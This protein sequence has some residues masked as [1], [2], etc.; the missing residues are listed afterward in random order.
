MNLLALSLPVFLF[1]SVGLHLVVRCFKRFKRVKII[2]LRMT[3]EQESEAFY[4]KALELVKEAG[5][6]SMARVDD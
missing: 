1:L 3:T 5:T 4:C 6:V 2:G